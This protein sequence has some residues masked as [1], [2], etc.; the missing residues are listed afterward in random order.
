MGLGKML[1]RTLPKK[2]GTKKGALDNFRL[3]YEV[4]PLRANYKGRVVRL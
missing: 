3:Q 1:Y 4:L 2:A